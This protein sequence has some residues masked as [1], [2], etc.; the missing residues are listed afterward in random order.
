VAFKLP[1]ITSAIPRDL[2]SFCD[3]VR[4]ALNAQGNDRIITRRDLIATGVVVVGPG[5]TLQPTD[6]TE[7]A[8]VKYDT[9]L[10]LQA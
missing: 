4:E 8:K 3:R 1:S 6:P 2:R 10:H 9:H 7:L 5:N